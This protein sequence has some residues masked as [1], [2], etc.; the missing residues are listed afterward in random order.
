MLSQLKQ[1]NGE[2]ETP[3]RRLHMEKLLRAAAIAWNPIGVVRRRM[4]SGTLTVGSVLVTFIGIVIACNLFGIGAQKFFIESVLYKAGGQLP[5]N[6]M[7]TSDYAQRLMSALGVLVPVGAVSLLPAGVF[8]PS[9]RGATVSAMLVVAAAWAFYGA[10]IG[11]PVH[12]VSGALA[13]VDLELGLRTYM[14]LGIPMSIA[15]IGLTIFF[16][17]RITLSVLELRVAQVIGI[18]MVAIIAIALVAG[19]I[20]FVGVA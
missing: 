19:F 2:G 13:T 3:E 5:A 16:W 10:A 1:L 9:G 20:V 14:L 4:E 8:H 15:I 12:F 18:S 6:P 7:I 11:V 17:F